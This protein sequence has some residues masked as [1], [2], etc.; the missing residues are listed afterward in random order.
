[1][2]GQRRALEEHV[3]RPRRRFL[4][5]EVGGAG[6]RALDLAIE[7][8]SGDPFAVGVGR[9]DEARGHV[10]GLPEQVPQSQRLAADRSRAVGGA[11]RE[12]EGIPHGRSSYLSPVPTPVSPSPRSRSPVRITL[13]PRPVPTT[14]GRPYS[15]L[16]IAACDMIPPRSDTVAL[17]RP[18]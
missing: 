6:Q 1:L 5:R 14:A 4:R 15:R 11:V 17:I 7:A 13:V 8:V 12:R 9:D 3:D 16:T 10:V 18:N 2:A